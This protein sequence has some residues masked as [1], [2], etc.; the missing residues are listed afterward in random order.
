MSKG[1]I[2]RLDQ[3]NQNESNPEEILRARSYSHIDIKFIKKNFN[4]W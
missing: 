1:G 2:F 4:L 3:K